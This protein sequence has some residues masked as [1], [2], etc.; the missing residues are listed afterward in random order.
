MEYAIHAGDH[1]V[2]TDAPEVYGGQNHGPKP[3]HMLLAG[4]M[5]A[6]AWTSHPS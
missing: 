1:V 4:L 2:I 3:T 5:A 6:R